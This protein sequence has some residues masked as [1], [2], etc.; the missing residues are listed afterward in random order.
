VLGLVLWLG[1]GLGLAFVMTSFCH[2]GFLSWRAFVMA[3]PN[4]VAGLPGLSL[5]GAVSC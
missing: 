1:L 4:P 2:G 3:G 5:Q